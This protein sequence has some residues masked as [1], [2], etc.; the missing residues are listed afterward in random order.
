MLSIIH[1]CCSLQQSSRTKQVNLE[2]HNRVA[3]PAPF[4]MPCSLDFG[5]AFVP[6]RGIVDRPTIHVARFRGPLNNLERTFIVPVMLL[7][8]QCSEAT[9]GQ[10]L[11]FIRFCVGFIFL[12]VNRFYP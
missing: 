1:V 6:E 8:C 5:T 2:G 10:Q 12:F 7:W 9:L 11:W 3:T 4:G